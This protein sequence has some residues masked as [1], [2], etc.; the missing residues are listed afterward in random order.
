M[1]LTQNGCDTQIYLTGLEEVTVK[2]FTNISRQVHPKETPIA[3]LEM[4]KVESL[5]KRRKRRIQE[6]IMIGIFPRPW[7]LAIGAGFIQK[8]EMKVTSALVYSLE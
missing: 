3:I 1:K 2:R 7:Y 6:Q 8:L 5:R 4:E